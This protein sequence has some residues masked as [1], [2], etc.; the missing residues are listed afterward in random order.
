[1]IHV[2]SSLDELTTRLDPHVCHV[3]RELFRAIPDCEKT[4]LL[5]THLIEEAGELC[6]RVAIFC[7]GQ[8]ISLDTPHVSSHASA[9]SVSTYGSL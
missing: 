4:I 7:R 8:I 5:S 6:D 1:M 3:V 9:S 2:S